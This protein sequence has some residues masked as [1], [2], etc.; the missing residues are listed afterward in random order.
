MHEHHRESFRKVPTCEN[1]RKF[2]IT[3]SDRYTID[4]KVQPHVPEFI[5]NS[6]FEEPTTAATPR[7]VKWIKAP[8][9]C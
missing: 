4:E 5:S 6:D 2:S 8:E 3:I 9:P 1:F 7:D